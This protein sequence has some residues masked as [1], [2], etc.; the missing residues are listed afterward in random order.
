MHGVGHGGGISVAIIL[1]GLVIVLLLVA[2]NR[3][4]NEN[5]LGM[6]FTRFKV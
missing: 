4:T 3:G 1:F 5:K 2:G 6:D